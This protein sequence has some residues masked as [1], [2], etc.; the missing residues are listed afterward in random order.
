VLQGACAGVGGTIDLAA[1]EARL[2][3]ASDEPAATADLY[4]MLTVSA[5]LLLGRLERTP[6]HAAAVLAPSGVALL[7]AG[8]ARAGKSTT[9]INLITAGWD[10][11]S[12]DQVV[13]SRAAGEDAL[14]VEGWPRVFH[15]DEGWERGTPTGRRGPVDAATLG[16]GRWRRTA[17]LGGLLFPTVRPDEPTHLVPVSAA[18]AFAG[19]VRQTPWL[20][21]DR[22]SSGA[23]LPLLSDAA[24]R[25]AF[26]LVLGLD[27]YRDPARLVRALEEAWR[28]GTTAR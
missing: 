7:L 27:S 21:V 25:P 2:T 5:A 6:V 10:Y 20:M 13:L 14:L 3:V 28:G 19:L 26:R 18:E 11:L 1:R 9:S 23:L 17:R 12:D 15:L 8:D 24:R 16:P 4:S 22:G